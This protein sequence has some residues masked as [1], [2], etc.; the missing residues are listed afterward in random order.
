M[1]TQIKYVVSTLATRCSRAQYGPSTDPS[2]AISCSSSPP[3]RP[4]PT[5]M[6]DAANPDGRATDIDLG[7][8][9]FM[10]T[11][12]TYFIVINIEKR[13]DLATAEAT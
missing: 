7:H 9:I 13:T 2:Q 11:R 3:R 8:N 4:L 6:P 12:K 1:W 5:P 10:K